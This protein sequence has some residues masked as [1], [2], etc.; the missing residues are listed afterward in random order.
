MSRRMMGVEKPS[1]EELQHYGIR[2]MKWG[3]RKGSLAERFRG[4]VADKAQRDERVLTRRVEGRSKGVE[5][6]VASAKDRILSGG[7]KRMIAK[8]KERIKQKREIQAR[9]AK[10]TLKVRDIL[11][12]IGTL[13]GLDFVTRGDNASLSGLGNLIVSRRDN[14]G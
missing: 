4:V 13:S 2:G 5:E 7:K 9:A 14:R 3:V 10:G 12:G 6:K 8:D 11:S 1:L